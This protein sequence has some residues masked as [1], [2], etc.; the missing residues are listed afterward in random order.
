VLLGAYVVWGEVC[1]GGESILPHYVKK[2]GK[3]ISKTF[4][5]LSSMNLQVLM[6][7]HGILSILYSS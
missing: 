1:F 4:L 2:R 5:R 7:E 3:Y 6:I